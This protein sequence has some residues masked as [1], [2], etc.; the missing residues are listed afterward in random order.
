MLA[1]QRLAFFNRS[2]FLD[3]NQ[4][5]ARSHDVTNGLIKIGFETQ[6]AIGYDA[7]DH[8][9]F[10][11]GKAGNL[12]QN[13]QVQNLTYRHAWRD[14]NRILQNTR[15][16]TFDFSHFSSLLLWSEI[17]MN[18]TDATFLRQ[19]N[20]QTGFG[21]CIHGGRHQRQTKGDISG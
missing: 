8:L 6:V 21:H 10:Y 3:C 15:L 13:R 12:V 5:L 2:P 17:L 7:N 11:Y 4:A 20:R 1:N 14:S 9:A 18:N 19:S 16:K